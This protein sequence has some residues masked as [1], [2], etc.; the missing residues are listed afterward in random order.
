MIHHIDPEKF[1]L[2]EFKARDEITDVYNVPSLKTKEFI[3]SFTKKHIEYIPNWIDLDKF[4]PLDKEVCRKE[5]G[6]SNDK[7]IIG[8]FQRDT[9]G[10]DLKK[11]KLSKG[12][13]RFCDF[14]E[15][16][17]SKGFDVH[18][19]LGG[20]RRQYVMNRL[21]K[22]GISY[23]Y[24]EMADAEKLNKM[25][26]S[27]SLYVVASRN[28]GGPAA[29]AECSALKVPIISSDVGIASEILNE[30][31]IVDFNDVD[32]IKFDSDVE[33]NYES[34]QYFDLKILAPKLFKLM[35]DLVND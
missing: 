6:L 20:W 3:E 26:C 27:L 24:Y 34:V 16:V 21:D 7:I 15:N 28:E 30:K 11:P 18:V 29:I 31:S 2:G 1:N 32:N 9:E 14:V 4:Q 22:A 12:P 23:T 5:L 17:F 13:D 10:S 8:S 19:L 33:Y 25:Y 35:K